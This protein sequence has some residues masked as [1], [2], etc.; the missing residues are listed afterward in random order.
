[1][2]EIVKGVENND[3]KT[4]V[5]IDKD[6]CLKKLFSCS[7][8]LATLRLATKYEDEIESIYVDEVIKPVEDILHNIYDEIEF[9]TP[10]GGGGV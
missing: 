4:L 8:I 7:C 10:K 2:S 1:M 5:L 9:R 6:E 3:N